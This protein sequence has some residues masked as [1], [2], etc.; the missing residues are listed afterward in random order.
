MSLIIDIVIIGIILLCLWGG[1]RKGLIGVAFSIVSFI[2]ALIIAFILFNPISSFVINNT[3]FDDNI[4]NSII[5]NF[6]GEEDNSIEENAVENENKN[7]EG[8]SENSVSFMTNYINKQIDEVAGNTLE[9]VATNISE[10][11]VKG[12]VFIGLFIVARIALAFFRMIA[13]FIA[14]LPLIHQFNKLG[15][16]VFGLLKGLVI[17]YGVL[18]IL[19]LV[20]PMFTESSF[21]VAMN[22]SFIGSMMY[23]NNII[24]KMLF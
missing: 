17:T 11:C 7:E 10:V 19:M 5:T 2:A 3:E 24:V 13:D 9:V 16:I 8:V 22:E 14:R 20:S 21:F 18:A 12:I 4:K 23:N 1:Y 15:G 6:S